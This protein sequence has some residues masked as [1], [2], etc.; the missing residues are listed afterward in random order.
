MRYKGILFDLDDT[1]FD[2]QTGNRNAVNALLDE[3][4]YRHPERYDQYEA[5]NLACWAELEQG[6][7]TQDALRAERFRRFY[8]QYGIARDPVRDGD[9]FVELLGMQSILL[10]HAEAVVRAIAAEKP[11]W[12]LTNGITQVQK[13]RL[14]LSPIRDV[15]SGVVIS[16]EVGAA[17]PNPKLFDHALKQMGVP[18]GEALMIGD[19]V[20][21]DIRGANNAGI[22]AC[23]Y[24]PAGKA[25][26][27]GVH[28]EYVVDDI[29]DCVDIALR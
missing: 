9:R 24:N 22:D 13:R 11:V 8:D 27:R 20:S 12:V 19:G 17:K 10:P 15:I 26:P 25:L 23:W 29:R 4:G 2:F 21:S 1:L 16:Q 28:A 3:I 7:L 5:V 18:R 14:A 6:K